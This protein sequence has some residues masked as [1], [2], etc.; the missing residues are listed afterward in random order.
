MNIGI[1]YLCTVKFDAF[2]SELYC[3]KFIN[4]KDGGKRR[5]YRA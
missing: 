3:L 4:L 5:M 1:E 2:Y